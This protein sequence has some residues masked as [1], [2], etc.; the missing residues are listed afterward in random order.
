M[1][2]YVLIVLVVL[3]LIGF[4]YSERVPYINEYE[5]TYIVECNSNK[6][7]FGSF[8]GSTLNYDK[9]GFEDEY[10]E[11]TVKYFC[12]NTDIHKS[13]YNSNNN[14]EANELAQRLLLKDINLTIGGENTPSKI[15][16]PKD[17]NFSLS[18]ENK[19]VEGSWI[20]WSTNL[21][22]HLLIVSIILIGIRYIYFFII[23]GKH[24]LIVNEK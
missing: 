12:E 16:I 20:K 5:S 18:I 24:K 1:V 3:T 7:T 13:H 10:I 14:T 6:Y 4:F 17:K 21:L 23:T 22:L 8:S 15:I 19:V 9:K 11:K 2:I